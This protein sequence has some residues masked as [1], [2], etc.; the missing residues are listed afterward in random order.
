[1]KILTTLF[2]LTWSVL[3]FGQIT[4]LRVLSLENKSYK[5]I[6]AFMLEEYTIIDDSKEYLYKPI[7]KCNPPIFDEDSCRWLCTQME[8]VSD[9]LRSKYPLDTIVF[10]ESSNKNYEV[11]LALYSIFGENYNPE[12]Q[13]AK[14]FIDISET[15]AWANNNC[16]NELR[17]G[18][19]MVN[20]VSIK[21]QFSDPYD[22]KRFKSSVAKN[23]T[24]Q[25][26]W[27][28]SEDTPIELRYGIR[29]Q[30]KNGVWK[31][32]LINLYEESSTYHARIHFDCRVD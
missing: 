3:S 9:W 18:E 2:L 5:E 20:S 6:Q 10:K 30:V 22:W 17:Y 12:T 13:T 7:K 28:R 31:G 11:N 26:T 16:Q 14:T 32:V 29:R 19:G 25:E 8:N 27:R 23:A 4:F 15:K 1:M 24:F 21:I